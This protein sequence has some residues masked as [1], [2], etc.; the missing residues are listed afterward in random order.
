MGYVLLNHRV[1][2]DGGY[3]LTIS[4][5]FP[6]GVDIPVY[7]GPAGDS[8]DSPCYGGFGLGYAGRS[9]DGV[10]LTVYTPPIASEGLYKVSIEVTGIVIYVDDVE[11]VAVPG[12][13]S[14]ES[15][16]RMVSPWMDTGVR[17]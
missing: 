11:V 16:E 1:G 12:K 9:I 4:G 13:T 17:K 15:I 5:W 10:N 2:I 14:V 7:V 8:T 6:T 3:D